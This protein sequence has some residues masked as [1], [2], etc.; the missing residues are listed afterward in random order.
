MRNTFYF[1]SLFLLLLACNNDKN[2]IGSIEKDNSIVTISKD[3]D[4]NS[5]M[6][7]VLELSS[8]MSINNSLLPND[9]RKKRI[10]ELSNIGNPTEEDFE[11][12]SKLCNF[13]NVNEFKIFFSD[14]IQSANIVTKKFPEL[15]TLKSEGFNEIVQNSDLIS[16][17]LR[18]AREDP[19]RECKN[20]YG[21]C[22][23]KTGAAGA[24]TI[25]ACAALGPLGSWCAIAA[26]TAT[27]A[28][29]EECAATYC[30]SGLL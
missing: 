8:K 12:M 26:T 14:L 27:I 2:L 20:G 13:S 28:G 9:I 30:G 25:I 19:R 23:V 29:Y 17:K 3:R 6:G 1:L 22:L 10:V 15:K 5:Y 11:E 4:F 7:K 21:A 24:A 18:S 16:K